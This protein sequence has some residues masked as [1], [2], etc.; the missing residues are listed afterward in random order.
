QQKI[1]PAPQA[2]APAPP[3]A[4]APPIPVPAPPP[5]AAPP[6]AAA[7][8]A[9]ASP[10]AA[11]TAPPAA[12]ASPA[13]SA[14]ASPRRRVAAPP[15][16]AEKPAP[17]KLAQAEPPPPPAPRKRSS[18]DPFE[19]GGS[20]DEFEKLLN[21]SPKRSVYVPPAPGG[22]VAEKVSTGQIQEA[23]AGKMGALREC[24]A[25]QQATDPEAHGEVTA[26][27]DIEPDG[28]PSAVS[29]GKAQGQPFAQCLVGV[30]KSIR[31]PRSR[32]GNKGDDK[33]RF[34]FRY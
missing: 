14:Q 22:E 5:Q 13:A 28:R 11:T 15:A 34:P 24:L 6:P 32:L 10:A 12:P 33:V 27:W 31:F 18:G 2:P 9:A 1:A 4:F 30:V 29:T 20:D 7:P 21:E 3:Q 16:P 17:K 8:P 26:T 19:G 25:R 23:V